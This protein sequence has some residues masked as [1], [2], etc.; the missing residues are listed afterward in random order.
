MHC[1]WRDSRL[2]ATRA[3][4]AGNLAEK[5]GTVVEQLG[6]ADSPQLTLPRVKYKPKEYY[7]FGQVTA[8]FLINV[9]EK[10]ITRYKDNKKAHFHT[11]WTP[12]Y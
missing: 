3:S 4:P 2:R 9:V 11:K 10:I 1:H 6:Y 5:N 12:E 8:V 7:R